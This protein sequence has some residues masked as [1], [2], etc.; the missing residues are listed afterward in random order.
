MYAIG[1]RGAN[2]HAVEPSEFLLQFDCSII[3]IQAAMFAASELAIYALRPS[4][5]KHNEAPPIM[6]NSPS[7]TDNPAPNKHLFGFIITIA[8]KSHRYSSCLLQRYTPPLLLLY[9][10]YDLLLFL[11]IFFYPTSHFY[12]RHS[13]SPFQCR[14]LHIYCCVISISVFVLFC[15]STLTIAS[16]SAH[17]TLLNRTQTHSRLPKEVIFLLC[18]GW[19]SVHSF[20]YGLL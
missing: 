20:L 8:S 5:N 6:L 4:P 3:L 19:T 9:L 18:D 1:L 16:I 2:W 7:G 13:P 10:A 11:L 15:L 17:G 14:G 12:L